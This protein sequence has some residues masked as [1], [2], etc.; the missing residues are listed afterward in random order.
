MNIKDNK[1]IIKALNQE[2]DNQEIYNVNNN[3]KINNNNY[4][5]NKYKK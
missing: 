5:I 4:M 2:N 3:N 1:T